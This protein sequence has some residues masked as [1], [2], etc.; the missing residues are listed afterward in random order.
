MLHKKELSEKLEPR[1]KAKVFFQ[2]RQEYSQCKDKKKEEEEGER[3]VIDEAV[4]TVQ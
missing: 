4:A 1:R 3:N 2:T